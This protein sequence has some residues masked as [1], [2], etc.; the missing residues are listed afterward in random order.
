MLQRQVLSPLTN[1]PLTP[2]RPPPSKFVS[3]STSRTVGLG[4]PT[5]ALVNFAAQDEGQQ[6]KER[7]RKSQAFDLQRLNLVGSPSSSSSSPSARSAEPLNGLTSTQLANHYAD[8]IQ[9][10]AE[11][12]INAKNAFALHLIDY[13]TE[14]VKKKELENFQVASSTLDASV[15]IYAGRVDSIHSQTYKVLSGLGGGGGKT[16]TD[17]GG[18][19][20]DGEAENLE[21]KPKKKRKTT[22]AQ[23]IETNLKNI[24]V[25]K[26]DLEFEVDP[27]F[28]MMSAAFDEGGVRGLLLNRLRTFDDSMQLVLDSSTVVNIV[29]DTNDTPNVRKPL[30]VSDLKDMLSKIK[31]EDKV[32]CPSLKDFH[33]SNW[34]GDTSFMPKGFSDFVFDPNAEPQHLPSV[35]DEVASIAHE[36]IDD[37]E[38]V[39]DELQDHGSVASECYDAISARDSRTAEFVESAFSD[40]V[41]G[42]VGKLRQILANEPSDYSYFN[43]VLMRTWAGPAHWRIGPTSK[44]DDESGSKVLKKRQKKPQIKLTYDMD[45]TE[46]NQMFKVTKSTYSKTTWARYLQKRIT[47]PRNQQIDAQDSLFRLF[48]RPHIMIKPQSV[49]SIGVDDGIDNYDYNN[50]NDVENFCPVVR[51]DDDEEDLSTGGFDLSNETNFPQASQDNLSQQ[52]AFSELVLNGTILTQDKLVAAPNKVQ[53]IDIKYAKTAKRV[54]VRKLKSTMWNILT[55]DSLE[56]KNISEPE[57]SSQ[58]MSIPHHFSHLKDVLP[59]K[60]S[61]SMAQNLTIQTVFACLLYITNEKSL[62]LTGSKEMDDIYIEPE[63]E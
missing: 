33:F 55:E 25:D 5:P 39:E 13:M 24:N 54:D 16:E 42:N 52:S 12:K 22:K 47:L 8:C 6:R 27:M 1:T 38:A 10:S 11:N 15:K 59:S 37:L 30:D 35:E 21:L 43:K 60:V 57:S 9:L 48:H 2:L 3:P 36:E 41:H 4:S 40:L 32:I 44:K 19:E 63:S 17:E 26:F 50:K 46:L 53:K 58:K 23:T 49:D 7:R 62:K 61:T 14:L 34:D 29:E 18:E 45:E 31:L 28:Q 20:V 56:T 51:E